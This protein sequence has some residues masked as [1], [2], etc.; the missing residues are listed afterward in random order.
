M[1]LIS[2]LLN[3]FVYLANAEL[4]FVLEVFRHG[5]RYPLEGSGTNSGELTPVG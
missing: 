3:C 4:K 5:A 2:L 1:I